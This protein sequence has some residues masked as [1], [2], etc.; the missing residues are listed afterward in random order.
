M[1]PEQTLLEY[2]LF[3]DNATKVEPDNNKKSN[4][5]QQ[6]DVVPAEWMNWAWYHNSKGVADLNKGV[7]SIEK[8]INNVLSSFG[9]SPAEATNNQLLT[10]MRLNASFVTAA[11]TTITG[12]LL[13]SGGTIRVMFTQDITGSDTTTGLTVNYNGATKAVKVS[14]DGVLTALTAH[15]I[16]T[17]VFKYIQKYTPLELYYDG[18]DFIIMGNPLVLSGTN[19]TIYADGKI[20]NE[21]IGDIKPKST[22]DIPYGW[23]EANGQAISRTKY[24]ELF[25]KYSTQTYDSDSTHTLLSRY[26]TGDGSTTFNLPDYR[27]V[28]LVGIGT[29]GTD[30]IA[31]HDIYTVGQFAD[32]QLQTH[33]HYIEVFGGVQ[34]NTNGGVVP[35]YNAATSSGQSRYASVNSIPN[36]RTGTTTHGKQKGVKYIIKVL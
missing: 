26:G 23:L 35:G 34:V 18:V 29:N 15:E 8:E 1:I 9:I 20:G 5:W 6:G 24:A 28:A 30:S 16:T 25:Q 36:A 14:K 21:N 22:N 4:G 11:S 3:G 13:V 12:P 2:P 17:N 19:Y 7:N 10:A 31:D 32:D 27:E 33:A